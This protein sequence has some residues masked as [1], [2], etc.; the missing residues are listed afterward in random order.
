ML[1]GQRARAHPGHYNAK[2]TVVRAATF[3][4]WVED[5]GL[6]GGVLRSALSSKTTATVREGSVLSSSRLAKSLYFE[7]E[8]RRV[9]QRY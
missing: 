2:Q 4:P 3:C 1:R 7:R 8:S 9:V 5:G 6:V